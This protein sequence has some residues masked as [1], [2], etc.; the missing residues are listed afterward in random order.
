M[1]WLG[2]RGGYDGDTSRKRRK[3]CRILSG[4]YAYNV[5][6]RED[7]DRPTTRLVQE[8]ACIEGKRWEGLLAL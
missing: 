1:P 3:F 7:L 4:V 5:A 6:E 8:C 2:R